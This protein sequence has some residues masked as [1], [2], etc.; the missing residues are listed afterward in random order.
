MRTNVMLDSW[1]AFDTAVKL[2]EKALT[3]GKTSR[4][5]N[6]R[7]LVHDNYFKFDKDWRNYK[8]DTIQKTCE[9]EVA[10]NEQKTDEDT[11]ITVP[12][13]Y[14]NDSWADVQM[15]TYSDV[16]DKLEE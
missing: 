1:G 13:F 2:S 7:Q 5:K 11:G 10:F 9:T 12:V 8:A 15:T 6:L 4:F 3:E 14:Y 16:I